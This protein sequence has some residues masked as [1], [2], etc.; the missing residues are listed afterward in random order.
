MGFAGSVLKQRDAERDGGSGIWEIRKKGTMYLQ[1]YG[2]CYLALTCTCIWEIPVWVWSF[3]NVCLFCLPPWLEGQFKAFIYLGKSLQSRLGFEFTAYLKTQQYTQCKFTLQL[4]SQ[5]LP[6]RNKPSESPLYLS[7]ML[8][9]SGIFS[10]CGPPIP[11][12]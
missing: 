9:V 3:G 10:K 8:K 4:T 12:L 11:F 1:D 7:L 6:R 2:I 5:E